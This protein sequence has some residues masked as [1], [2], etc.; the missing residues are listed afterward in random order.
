M[1]TVN[2]RKQE[3]TFNYWFWLLFTAQRYASMVYAVFVCLSVC[4]TLALC[5]ND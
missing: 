4:H 2:E 5:Q 3:H 1:Y